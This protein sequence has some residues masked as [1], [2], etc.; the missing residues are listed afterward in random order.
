MASG[1]RV[2]TVRPDLQ[3]GRCPVGPTPGPERIYMTTFQD[4]GLSPRLLTALAKTALTT[5]T[6]IQAQAIPYIM[7]GRDLMG[8]AQTGT[9]KTAAFGHSC[10]VCW[11]SATRRGRAM[12]VR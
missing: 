10:T 5:P 1:H 9:G 7:Q 12:C 3:S 8:L 11:I 6:P 2:S 4:L